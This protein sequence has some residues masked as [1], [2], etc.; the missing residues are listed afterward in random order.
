MLWELS[1]H[2]E[3]ELPN[4]DN[5]LKPRL[6]G[7]LSGAQHVAGLGD[8]RWLA[9]LSQ[10]NPKGYQNGWFSKWQVFIEREELGP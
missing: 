2:E 9:N 3:A 1:R 10:Q 4:P 8:G 6:I 5:F 7:L